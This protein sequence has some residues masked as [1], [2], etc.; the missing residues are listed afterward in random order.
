VSARTRSGKQPGN[1]SKGI[2][3]EWKESEVL[4]RSVCKEASR[5]TQPLLREAW[6]EPLQGQLTWCCT[7]QCGILKKTVE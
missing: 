2:T 5:I 6:G 4:N 7:A 3:E 1:K